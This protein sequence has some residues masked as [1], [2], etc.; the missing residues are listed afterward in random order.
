M[1]QDL[2]FK[3]KHLIIWKGAPNNKDYIKFKN[4]LNADIIKKFMEKDIYIQ[5]DKTAIVNQNKFYIYVYDDRASLIFIL[6]QFIDYNELIE[7]I[8]KSNEII[9]KKTFELQKEAE[10]Y[11]KDIAL[12]QEQSQKI[13]NLPILP[14]NTLNE[15]TETITNPVTVPTATIPTST[16]V[17]LAVNES[18]TVPVS[19]STAL[20]PDPVPAPAPVPAPFPVPD[21]VFASKPNPVPVSVSVPKPE[22]EPAS[23]PAST[24]VPISTPNKINNNTQIGGNYYRNKYIQYKTKYIRLKKMMNQ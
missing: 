21:S 18:V 2:K 12:K 7:M 16:R 24:I 14:E 17:P 19:S 23:V 10:Q 6:D 1:N 3:N 15:P 9:K 20:V 4:S 22:P 11:R 8:E 5:E 13:S